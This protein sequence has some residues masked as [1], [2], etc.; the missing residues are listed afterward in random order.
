MTVGPPFV[1]AAVVKSTLAVAINLTV[2][3]EPPPVTVVAV[4]YVAEASIV[5]MAVKKTADLVEDL[6]G[7]LV[8]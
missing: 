7:K 3:D 8:A 2:V 1:V 4:S 5:S 6:V